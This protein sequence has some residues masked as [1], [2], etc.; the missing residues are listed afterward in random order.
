MGTTGDGIF[1]NSFC[2]CEV[3]TDQ[4][5]RPI[6]CRGN[7]DAASIKTCDRGQIRR[8]RAHDLSIAHQDQIVESVHNDL[9][10]RDA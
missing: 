1:G 6:A 4:V 9:E 3:P 2:R 7:N 10:W 8:Q 5:V